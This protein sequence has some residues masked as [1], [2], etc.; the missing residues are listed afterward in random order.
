MSVERRFE[1]LGQKAR[2]VQEA[3]EQVRGC[4]TV[5]GVRIEVG[6]DGRITGLDVG[7]PQLAQ[8][9]SEAHARALR[10]AGEQ[11]GDLRRELADDPMVVS[12][13]R[14]LLAEEVAAEAE[15]HTPTAAPPGRELAAP[16]PEPEPFNEFE[17]PDY[18]NPYALPPDVQRRYGLR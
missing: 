13:T 6:A 3:V 4:A 5:P 14:R 7:N 10:H 11:V 2:R 9:I 12:M 17:D 15:S 16:L 8:A 1:E 18:E